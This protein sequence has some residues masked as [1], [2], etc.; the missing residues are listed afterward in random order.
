[1]R[2]NQIKIL[3][4]IQSVL[5]SGNVFSV[6]ELSKKTGLHYVTVKKYIKLIETM[7]KMP[8]IEIIKSNSTTLI[9]LDN[10]KGVFKR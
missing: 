9:R 4:K 1:M 7:K 5:S 8:E 2:I 6:H 10:G 3:E